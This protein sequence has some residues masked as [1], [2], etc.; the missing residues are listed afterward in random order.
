MSETALLVQDVQNGALDLN[1]DPSKL[2]DYL[3]RL[4]STIAA[5]RKA[6]IKIIYIIASFRPGHPEIH[7]RTKCSAA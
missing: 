3:A 5:A 4:A 6:G 2:E 7:P 1:V